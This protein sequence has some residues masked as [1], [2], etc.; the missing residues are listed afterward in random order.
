MVVARIRSLLNAQMVRSRVN[1][2]S[3]IVKRRRSNRILQRA[4]DCR[5]HGS[6]WGDRWGDFLT[7]ADLSYKMKFYGSPHSAS[8]IAINTRFASAIAN[9]EDRRLPRNRAASA[10]IASASN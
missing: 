3:L 9:S 1:L 5:F 8:R 10:V 6:S 4:R 7:L 2:E